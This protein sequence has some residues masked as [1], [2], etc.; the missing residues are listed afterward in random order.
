MTQ[1]TPEAHIFIHQDGLARFA[2]EPYNAGAE[3]DKNLYMH[4]TNYAINKESQ[5]FKG[6]ESDFKKSQI[7]T[8]EIIKDK[9]GEQAVKILKEKIKDII[10]KTILV[11]QPHL[12]HNYKT[13]M[14]KTSIP[15]N[16]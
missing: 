2:T 1:V 9:K 4:L 15:N 6:N 5:K 12:E 8:L 7:E 11:G 10:I 16:H 14:S 3:N 13:C